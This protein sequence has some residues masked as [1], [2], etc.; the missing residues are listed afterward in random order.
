M[1][2]IGNAIIVSS[3]SDSALSSSSKRPVQNKIVTEAINKT[4]GSL[5]ATFATNK[6]YKVGDYCIYNGTLYRFKVAHSA[7][8][9]NVSHVEAAAIGADLAQ[10]IIDHNS[11]VSQINSDID[12]LES[13]LSND[14][15][16]ANLCYDEIPRTIQNYTFS[17]GT[18][19]KVS[20]M[21]NNTEIRSDVFM[22]SD[23]MITEVR[24]LNSGQSLTIQTNLTTLETIVTY[25]AA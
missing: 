7:G 9:W 11:T 6:T 10:F 5:A 20:H 18:V 3:T 16:M 17:G 14:E 21:R 24:T 1:A 15:I 22:Y 8:A 13:D 2:V 12:S 4:N 25:A 23:S 19:S